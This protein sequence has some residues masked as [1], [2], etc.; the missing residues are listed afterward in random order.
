MSLRPLFVLACLATLSLA[1]EA[2]V[3]RLNGPLYRGF[4]KLAV[5]GR[6][7]SDGSVLVWVEQEAPIWFSLHASRTDGTGDA[8]RILELPRD[9]IT[10]G[11]NRV[12]WWLSPSG[13]SVVYVARPTGTPELFRVD[14][15]GGDPPARISDTL[16]P[17][18]HPSQGNYRLVFSPD[19]SLV[20][21]PAVAP[22][23]LVA[24]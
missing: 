14:T 21:F 17:D 18:G 19:D 16:V 7:S 2:Q 5:D 11:Y 12:T 13:E 15:F 6:L 23:V 9:R 24:N 4:S 20:A 22:G 8:N 3:R 10:T 1:P